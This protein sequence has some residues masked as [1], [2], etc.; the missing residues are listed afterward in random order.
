[1]KKL[2]ERIYDWIS[3]KLYGGKRMAPSETTWR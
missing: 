1:M 2:I 3:Y